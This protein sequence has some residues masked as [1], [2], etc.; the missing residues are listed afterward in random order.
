MSG[1]HLISCVC[2]RWG[3][4]IRISIKIQVL[5]ILLSKSLRGK[6]EQQ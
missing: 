4:F 5:F 6:N 3:H 2:L 1:F